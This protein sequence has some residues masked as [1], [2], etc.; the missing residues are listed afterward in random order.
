M[1]STSINFKVIS[2]TQPGVEN[3]R[4]GFEPATFGFPDLPGQQAD[5]LTHLATPTG[6]HELRW[7]TDFI[8]NSA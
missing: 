4:S 7:I 1:P 2:L 6:F 3:A 8:L 5:A